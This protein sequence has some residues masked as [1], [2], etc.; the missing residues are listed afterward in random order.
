MT[1][2]S[3]RCQSEIEKAVAALR[4]AGSGEPLLGSADADAAMTLE[5]VAAHCTRADCWVVVQGRVLDVTGFISEHPG[6]E[7]EL[8]T[9]AGKDVT[10]IFLPIH[11]EG[12]ALLGRFPGK[13][14]QVGVLAA[15]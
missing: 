3:N 9:R 15:S 12:L 6:G 11:R 2:G 8:L 10:R 14:R 13:I 4:G 1:L 5:E 7:K